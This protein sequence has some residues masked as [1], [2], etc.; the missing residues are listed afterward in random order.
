MAFLLQWLFEGT[1]E[2]MQV[3][4][5]KILCESARSQQVR[6]NSASVFHSIKHLSTS[7][8]QLLLYRLDLQDN[9]VSSLAG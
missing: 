5:V 2:G 3:N 9:H 4:K 1:K 8:S 6:G 7:L